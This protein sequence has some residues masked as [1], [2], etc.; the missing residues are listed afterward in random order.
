MRVTTRDPMTGNDVKDREN[1][2]CIT[3]GRGENALV[4]YFETENSRQE[5]LK[6]VA[7]VP[8]KCSLRLYKSFEDDETILW[9]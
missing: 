3:E 7:R 2:P 9:D 1:A 6:I 5:Y 8:E 4:I